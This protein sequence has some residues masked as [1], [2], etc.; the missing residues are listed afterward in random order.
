MCLFEIDRKIKSTKREIAPL[1]CV[2]YARGQ[3]VWTKGLGE[4]GQ[5]ACGE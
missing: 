2:Y 3:G 4:G 1:V 5:G